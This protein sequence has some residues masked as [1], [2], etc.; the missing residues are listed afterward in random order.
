MVGSLRYRS[1]EKTITVSGTRYH[2][3]LAA[4]MQN[5]LAHESL[6]QFAVSKRACLITKGEEYV[7]STRAFPPR[8]C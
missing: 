7:R 4:V 8:R 5:A 3:A 2:P 1:A 6:L